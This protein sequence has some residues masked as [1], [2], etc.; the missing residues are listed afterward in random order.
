MQQSPEETTASAAVVER[1]AALAPRL[2]PAVVILGVQAVFFGLSITPGIN[3]AVR[4]GYMM[5]GPATCVLLF[6]IWLLGFSRL[7]WR[8]RFALLM[9]AS[10]LGGLAALLSDPTMGVCLWIYGAPLA[11]LAITVALRVSRGKAGLARLG[12]ASVCLA[13]TWLLFPLFRLDGFEGDYLPELAW[14]WAPTAE[15]ALAQDTGEVKAPDGPWTPAAIEW[16]GFRGANCDAR[17]ADSAADL[18]WAAGPKVLWS[19]PVGPAWS[20]FAHVGGR[21]FTQEQRDQQE[22][23]T[24]VDAATGK[25]IWRS[26]YPCR[27]T[28]VVAGAGPRATPTYHEGKLYTFRSKAVLSSLDA[29]S[30]KILWQ[31]DLMAEVN[32]QLPV[33]GFSSSPL[34]LGGN[35]I[36]YAGGDGDNGLMAFKQDTGEVS[37]RYASHGMNFSSAQRV[38]LAGRD[39]VVFGDGGGLVALDP[40]GGAVVWKY[41]PAGWRG[42]AI[43]QP[44]QVGADSLIVPLGDGIGVCRLV[45]SEAGGQWDFKE[46][47]TSKALKP[48]FNDFVYHDGFLYGFD[49]HLFVCVDANTGELKWKHKGY[50]F[51]Q[52]LLLADAGKLAVTAENGDTVL[53]AADPTAHRELGRAPLLKGKTWN[54]PI[55]AAGRLFVRNGETM[56]A[57]ALSSKVA[58]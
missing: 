42:P 11:M 15:A 20:S 38:T 46:A 28:D 6:L 16:P 52:V 34:L 4:F 1:P 9:V 17:V 33:W 37:W 55:A 26:V 18:D 10:L 51:G 45:V 30:G 47:W 12:V 53:L 43:C 21:L 49:N 3:N 24:C 54:H 25:I 32:A 8:E 40:A 41:K 48:S 39:L 57:V 5:A 13:A 19:M 7:P 2:W 29:A 56:V 44:Q 23:V 35:A 36:V 27:F 58:G 14:R 31:H 22:A 50:G